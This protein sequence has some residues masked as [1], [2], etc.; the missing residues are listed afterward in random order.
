MVIGPS[1]VRSVRG[2][3]KPHYYKYYNCIN[4][5]YELAKIKPVLGILS[6]LI[7]LQFII[8]NLEKIFVCSRRGVKF[9]RKNL[10]RFHLSAVA[11]KTF[12][13]FV[14]RYLCGN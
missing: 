11:Q 8:Q 3:L 5:A 10:T 7:Q 9:W 13:V 2:S 4:K 12:T 6:K 14:L 1:M